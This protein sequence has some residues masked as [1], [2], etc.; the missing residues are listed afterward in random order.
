MRIVLKATVGG[1]AA[2]IAAATLTACG[3]A[4]MPLRMNDYN[5]I[6]LRQSLWH[7]RHQMFLVVP[8]PAFNQ[9][10]RIRSVEL[11]TVYSTGQ[12]D[13]ADAY[14]LVFTGSNSYHGPMLTDENA[15]S[16][17]AEA[18][19]PHP[20]LDSR[21]VQKLDN[22]LSIVIPVNINQRGC[23]EAQV[24]FHVTTADGSSHTRAAHWYVALDTGISKSKDFKKCEG[25]QAKPT[26][27]ASHPA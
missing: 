1:V 12:F 19:E 9:P 15:L 27:S 26:P 18:S 22:Q 16:A 3:N 4:A 17:Y 21:V 20:P 11:Q 23:H 13:R 25:P 2:V 14:L 8:T 5:A 10:V 6:A 7:F 24:I